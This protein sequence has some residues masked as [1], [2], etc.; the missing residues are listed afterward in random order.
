MPQSSRIRSTLQSRR[1]SVAGFEGSER[2]ERLTP[3]IEHTAH[4]VAELDLI[5]AVIKDINFVSVN[6]RIQSHFEFLPL[7]ASIRWPIRIIITPIIKITWCLVSID[8]LR[9]HPN[10]YSI[11]TLLEC[12]G[13]PV[14]VGN[15]NPRIPG[16]DRCL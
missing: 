15:S 16:D 13:A 14:D 10:S 11:E 12:S 8:Q 4:T 5:C 1:V 6:R 9:R 2:S 3:R 7:L